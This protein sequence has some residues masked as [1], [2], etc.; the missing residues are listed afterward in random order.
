MDNFSDEDINLFCSDYKLHIASNPLLNSKI[1]VWVEYLKTKLHYRQ[2]G[3]DED[4]FFK[5]RFGITDSDL[6]TIHRLID[7]IKRGKTLTKV[8]N[9]NIKGTSQTFGSNIYSTF[10]ETANYDDVKPR[11]EIMNEIAPAM[12]AYNRKMKKQ[13][14]RHKWKQSA[15]PRVWEDP[16]TQMGLSSKIATHNDTTRSF[17]TS[18]YK[19]DN[20]NPEGCVQDEPDRYYNDDLYSTRP[21]IEFD[22]Q[23]FARSQMYNMNKTNIIQQLDQMND[24]LD[25][26]NLLTNEFDDEYKRAIPVINS[27]KK[28][29]FENKIDHCIG[30]NELNESNRSDWK[31]GNGIVSGL[32]QG[33]GGPSHYIGSPE[34][35][36][37]WQ[38][39]DLLADRGLT[40][41]PAIDNRNPF[42]HQFDYL[43]G[44]YNRVPDPRIVGTSSRLENRTTFK[45]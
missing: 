13:Q 35:T 37:L 17:D 4:Y 38:D 42:E 32:E 39:V 27:K 1:P 25:S 45:R 24:I 9:T 31:F 2:N 6:D 40:R 23:D 18:K 5:R 21:Q 11:F 43:D 3:M 14:K 8:S 7:R 15:N 12:E 34:A 30:N 26:N 16:K 28:V 22:V 19:T 29:S 33:I 20:F 44:N 10:I 41:K 36:R